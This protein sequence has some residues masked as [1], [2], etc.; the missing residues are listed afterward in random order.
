[1][2]GN[3]T[4]K[5]S[6]FHKNALTKALAIMLAILTI[7]LSLPISASA[8][9]FSDIPSGS[10][11]ENDVYALVN[12]GI[13]GGTG[14]NKF[15]PNGKISRA[16]CAKILTLMA[17][18]EGELGPFKGWS[19]FKDV[20]ANSWY[21]PYINWA[22]EAGIISGYED[23]TFRPTRPVNRQELAVMITNFASRMGYTLSTRNSA[24]TFK[25]QSRIGKWAASSVQAC[26]RAG[27]IGGYSDGSFNPL[28]NTK[29][30]ESAAMFNRFINTGSTKGDYDIYRKRVGGYA[31]RSVVFDSNKY[32]GNILT[33]NDRVSSSETMSSMISRTGA[34]FA[35]NAS[36]F[37]MSS[38]VPEATIVKNGNVVVTDKGGAKAKPSFIVDSQGKSYI[39]NITLNQSVTL[40]KGEDVYTYNSVSKNRAPANAKDATRIIFDRTWGNTIGVYARDALVV[41]N[42]VVTK[43]VRQSGESLTIPS[44]GYIIYQRAR[45]SEV[46]PEKFPNADDFFEKCQVGDTIDLKQTYTDVIYN[47]E[48]GDVNH[49][50]ASGPRIVKDGKA[51]NNYGGE[52]FYAGDIVGGGNRRRVAIG[53][54]GGSEAGTVV[55]VTANCSVQRLADIMVTMGCVDAMNLDGGGSTGL[56][57]DGRWLY[58]PDR[59]LS[60]I[61]YFK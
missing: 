22:Y 59:R 24:K 27:I 10:W 2:K 4:I 19:T 17:M 44:N 33:A 51:Y 32:K 58:S 5:S 12:K 47:T 18:S 53:I 15:T 34:K 41:E 55:I 52:G 1:M 48:I 11:Y 30:S 13:I 38:Y 39:K 8:A 56:Y 16:E 57:V 43:I 25:D 23:K 42:G 54:K 40:Q 50:V 6:N 45:R 36:Y 3:S 9:K 37:D 49:S 31:I 28:H 20:G 61:I 60:N 26:Q 14:N 29:R 46:D 35:V 21:T 7:M